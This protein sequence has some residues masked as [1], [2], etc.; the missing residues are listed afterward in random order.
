MIHEK[1]SDR[2]NLNNLFFFF[3]IG[4]VTNLN[5][6]KKTLD[7]LVGKKPEIVQKEHE[8]VWWWDNLS[9]RI[10]VVVKK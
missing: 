7:N 3:F 10:P 9:C 2:K 4:S 8:M 1:A 6:L 5:N